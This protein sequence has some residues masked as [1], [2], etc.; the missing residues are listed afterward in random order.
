VKRKL[1]EI[2]PFAK[3]HTGEWLRG[4]ELS[5][6]DG[7]IRIEYARVLP[8]GD[9]VE[10][11]TIETIPS[12]KTNKE[13]RHNESLEKLWKTRFAKKLKRRR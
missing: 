5:G 12:P 1:V 7:M 9:R 10:V 4:R 3:F 6:E 8:E 2:V 11:C 13:R